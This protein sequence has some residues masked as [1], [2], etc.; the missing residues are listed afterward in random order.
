MEGNGIFLP[1][2]CLEDLTVEMSLESKWLGASWKNPG[3]V[4]V[5]YEDTLDLTGKSFR[6]SF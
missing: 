1:C 5:N 3:Q 6:L 2:W 4:D